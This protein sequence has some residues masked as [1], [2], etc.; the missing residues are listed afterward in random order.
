MKKLFSGRLYK[1]SMHQTIGMGIVML[2]L[3][4]VFSGFVPFTSLVNSRNLASGTVNFVNINDFSGGYLYVAILLPFALILK[5]FSYLFKRSSSDFYHALPYTRQCLFITGFVSALTWY[6]ACTLVAVVTPAVLYGINEKTRFSAEFV[7]LN[8]MVYMVI[9]LYVTGAVLIAASVVGKKSIAGYFALFITFMPRAIMLIVLSSIQD[10][11][12]IV[13]MYNVFWFSIKYN[14]IF[15]LLVG[16]YPD[17]ENYSMAFTY[18]PGILITFICA[19]ALI[20]LGFVFFMR[21]KSETAENAVPNNK[22]QMVLQSLLT[23]SMFL[24]AVTTYITYE[25]ESDSVAGFIIVGIIAYIVYSAVTYRKFKPVIKTMPGI[26]VIFVISVIFGLGINSISNEILDNPIPAENISTITVKSSDGTM[27]Y[28]TPTYNDLL[29]REL[30]FDEEEIKNIIAVAY[31][32]NCEK[33]KQGDSVFNTWNGDYVSE[34]VIIKTKSGGTFHRNLYLTGE[35]DAKLRSILKKQ[36]EYYKAYIAL[37]EDCE[38]FTFNKTENNEKLL[39]CFIEEFDEL[40][41]REKEKIIYSETFEDDMY[42][43]SDEDYDYDSTRNV[44]VQ[45]Y[46]NGREYSN[47]YE[48]SSMPKTRELYDRLCYEESQDVMLEFFDDDYSDEEWR[49]LL[50]NGLLESE[51]DM[52]SNLTLDLNVGDG[53]MF[54][55]WINCSIYSK[56]KY[57]GGSLD[58]EQYEKIKELILDIIETDHTVNVSEPSVSVSITIGGYYYSDYKDGSLRLNYDKDKVSKLIEYIE[59]ISD[60]LDVVDDF[61]Y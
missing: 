43:D 8:F 48:I 16:Q 28:Y 61:Y 56:E 50:F 26:L 53:E 2:F 32:D 23:F 4:L 49:Y 41:D 47:E 13:D 30:E 59:E 24:M 37:P 22:A 17:S 39:E 40:T 12:R 29:I 5:L 58:E 44:R 19:V 25:N 1:E 33:V 38:M 27:Y 20:A 6:V 15:E 57:Y 7:P 34:G 9:I 11:T 18:I 46:Y 52:L 54:S 35:N 3:S 14:L 31:A 55:A 36:D 45:G 10:I 42:Y 51:N 60:S 21:R